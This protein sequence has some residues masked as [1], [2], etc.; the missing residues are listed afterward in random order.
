MK[1]LILLLLFPILTFS[2]L[3]PTIGAKYT[4]G[5]S[6]DMEH[7]YFSG[8][9]GLMY[10][11]PEN[12]TFS[13]VSFTGEYIY[14]YSQEFNGK[15]N[16]YVLKLQTAN[17]FTEMFGLTYYGGYINNFQNDIMNSFKGEFKTNLAFGLG[18]RLYADNFIA[19]ALYENLAG[20]PHLSVGFNFK[21]WNLTK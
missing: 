1:K 20:Y 14:D 11:F 7:E 8:Q 10:S 2:Q 5:L 18:I 19:E 13:D 6:Y 12:S 4:G 3:Q 15:H 9:L 17:K 16:F 21:L